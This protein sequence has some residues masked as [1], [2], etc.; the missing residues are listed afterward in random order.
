MDKKPIVSL[1]PRVQHLT[2]ESKMKIVALELT[3]IRL[4]VSKEQDT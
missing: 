2:L 4:S 1:H 3:A